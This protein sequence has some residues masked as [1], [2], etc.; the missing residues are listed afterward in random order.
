MMPPNMLQRACPDERSLV[1]IEPFGMLVT[2]V[3]FWVSLL[4]F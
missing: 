3:I 1:L 2:A 4:D